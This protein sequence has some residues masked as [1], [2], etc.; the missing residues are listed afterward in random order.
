MEILLVL[1][2]LVAELKKTP[3]DGWN[4][5]PRCVAG[6]ETVTSHC[7]SVGMMAL[8]I[9]K[10][11]PHLAL[12]QFKLVLL[13]LIHDLVEA[14]TSDINLFRV[15]AGPERES[16]RVEKRR[17]EQEAIEQIRRD[18]G[19][20][21]GG[22]IYDLWQEFEANETA[23]AKVG[24]DLDKIETAVQACFYF[25]DG[26]RLNPREFFDSCRAVVKTPELRAFLDDV[27][28]P[29][30]PAVQEVVARMGTA[31]PTQS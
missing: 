12:D 3:R 30:L 21:V 16:L 24:H 8:A 20:S 6:A 22:Q 1:M 27:L 4:M 2:R 9:P 26:H 18:L 29:R 25:E 5:A 31:E 11:L 10:L 23:E 17:R 14:L 13:C 15:P 7:Y 19:P 28:L